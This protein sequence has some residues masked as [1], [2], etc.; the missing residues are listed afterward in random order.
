[1]KALIAIIIIAL[2]AFVL[3]VPPYNL[4]IPIAPE[5]IPRMEEAFGSILG[6][7]DASGQPRPANQ[8]EIETATAQWVGQSIHDY[9]RRKNMASFT[10][11]PFTGTSKLNGPTP[12]PT[13][14]PKKK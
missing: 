2:A 11:P 14:T 5:D 12:V 9:E 8:A 7:R 6:L 10:P 1:M 4:T 13:P 3:G